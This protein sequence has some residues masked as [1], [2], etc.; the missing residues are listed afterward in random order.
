MS[1]LFV[2]VFDDL[3]KADECRILLR[4]RNVS[5]NSPLLSAVVV[6]MENNGVARVTHTKC[7]EEP[8]NPCE[9]ASDTFVRTDAGE[10][11]A[12][13]ALS[14]IRAVKTGDAVLEHPIV[15]ELGRTLG[16]G[17]SALFL[18][19]SNGWGKQLLSDLCSLPGHLIRTHLTAEEQKDISSARVMFDDLKGHL[20]SLNSKCEARANA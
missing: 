14:A 5:P 13:M 2:A 15:K 4:R 12:G 19:S 9:S 3:F 6:M 7:F 18:M 10:A 20:G 11:L 1:E 8:A 17:K 16:N